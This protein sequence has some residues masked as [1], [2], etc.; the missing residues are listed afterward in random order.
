MPL[1]PCRHSGHLAA[2]SSVMHAACPQVLT[3]GD[4]TDSHGSIAPSKRK[5]PVPGG[6]LTWEGVHL[7]ATRLPQLSSLRE[8]RLL[9][10][11]AAVVS[12]FMDEVMIALAH[13]MR[14]LPGLQV[15][16]LRGLG[17]LSVQAALELAHAVIHAPA[18]SLVDLS[19]AHVGPAALEVLRSHTA[20]AQPHVLLPEPS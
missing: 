7:L 8:V 4:S 11:G 12:G 2:A 16:D 18:L 3:L 9:G 13:A 1:R 17:W 20:D 15:L 10:L 6:G 5:A 14:M 19:A